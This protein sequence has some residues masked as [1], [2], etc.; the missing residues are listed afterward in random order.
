MYLA[1]D[2]LSVLGS[3]ERHV[4]LPTSR[5]LPGQVFYPTLLTLPYLFRNEF[6]LIV[7]AALSSSIQIMQPTAK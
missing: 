7:P 6:S 1:Y 3:R 5:P 2:R 4:C